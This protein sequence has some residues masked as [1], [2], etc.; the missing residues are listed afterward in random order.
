MTRL[1]NDR[2]ETTP[3]GGLRIGA[4]VRNSD[5]A[6][7]TRVRS[8]YPALAEAVLAGA[9]GQL[10]NQATTG[11]NL[12]QRTRCVYFQDA[13]KPCNKR[14]PGS[15]CPA[16]RGEHRNLA[17]IGHSEQCVATHPS[18][19]AVAL[20]AFDGVAWVVGSGGERAIPLVEFHRLPGESP[21]RDSVLEPG[22]LI[23][24]VELPA[25]AF[26]ANSRYRKV[27]ERRILVRARLG[28][29]GARGRGG[30]G[31]RRPD[32]VRRRRTQALAGLR[33]GGRATRVAGGSPA[34]RD[35][36]EAELAQARPLRDNAYKLDLARNILVR[37][38][39]GAFCVSVMTPAVGMPLDR[40]EGWQKVAGEA[41]YAFEHERDEVA[42]AAIVQSTIAK[43]TIRAIDTRAALA[44]EGVLAVLTREDA[45]RSTLRRG[46]SRCSS[47]SRCP[48]EVR[49]SPRRSQRAS[50]SRDTPQTSCGRLRRRGARR[51]APA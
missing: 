6:A 35:A 8:F 43:G 4:G 15:G 44:L 26:A 41:L 5:L 31:A 28:G 46:S 48:T 21:E 19:M 29:R 38:L 2:I 20:A 12:L 16:R 30:D 9:S 14:D 47:R 22:E 24:A 1:G 40:V 51:R 3:G 27:R 23:V 13:T 25:L 36:A 10:R 42:Y 32:R 17:I 37:T 34:F 39:R 50:R 7:D 11:G 49:S 18:D 33:R 45:P